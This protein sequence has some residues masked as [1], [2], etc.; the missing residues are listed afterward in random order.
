MNR[1][2]ESD[3]AGPSFGL[4]MTNDRLKWLIWDIETDGLDP[5]VIHCLVTMDEDGN[6]KRYNHEVGNFQEGLTSL[7]EADLLIGHNIIGFD[8][9][10]IHKLYPGWSTPA[11]LRDTLVC[12]R[13]AWP[14]RRDLDFKLKDFPREL[15]GSHSLKS[16]GMRLGYEKYAYGER[17]DAFERWSPELE[18]YC[19]R[20]V[21]ITRRLWS[22]FLEERLPPDAVMLEHELHDICEVMTWRGIGF[23]REAAEKLYA[24][25]LAEKDQ[26]EMEL[27]EVFPPKQI[28]MKTKVKEIP[29]NP[30]SRVQIGERFRAQGWAPSE[31]TPDGRPKINDVIL[32][33]LSDTYPEAI[34]LNRYL[35]I[36][37]R[38]GQ[39]ADG[40]RSWLGA[41]D[42]GGRIH[43]RAITCGGTIS[44]RMV[45]HS[46]NLTQ[47]PNINAEFGKECR[48]LFC[49][50]PGYKL[51]GT[52]LSSIELRMLAHALAYWDDGKFAAEV[53]SGDPH[54]VTADQFG[55]SR[56]QGKLVN[57]SLIY[58]AGDQRLGQAIGGDRKEGRNLRRRFYDANPAFRKFVESVQKKTEDEGKLRGLDGRTL[59]PR[60]THSAVNLW[61]QNAAAIVAKRA[62]LLHFLFLEVQGVRHPIDFT[63][64]VFAHDE[65][66][67]EIIES[68]AAMASELALHAMKEAG[69]YYDLKVEITGETKVGQTWADTH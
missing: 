52:D 45:L 8:L 13:L 65:W 30:G 32:S 66:Q 3:Q 40:K 62:T 28:Q 20:D 58:G 31:F 47:V 54:Q 63:L 59:Y 19:V 50:P 17:E 34:P 48:A 68:E 61:I 44:H 55:I 64:A 43:G 22:L 12:S 18:D 57:F 4:Q 42:E 38:I 6:L 60:S 1:N 49:A 39:L 33:E 29:F 16:W 67:L 5:T 15:I 7:Q 10:V 41:C 14:H 23:D 25:L 11:S 53:E 26:L 2:N 46:P 36:Q 21:E 51:V 9:Q 56:R 27:Q 69:V 35:L 24:R 37:K